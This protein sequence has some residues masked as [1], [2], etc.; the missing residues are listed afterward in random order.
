[1][2]LVKS[3]HS[4]ESVKFS[5]TLECNTDAR[6][7]TSKLFVDKLKLTPRHSDSCKRNQLS[8]KVPNL[9]R[10]P[11]NKIRKKRKRTLKS[12]KLVK[13]RIKK[14]NKSLTSVSS[15]T[16]RLPLQSTNLLKLVKSSRDASWSREKRAKNARCVLKT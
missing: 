14:S 7:K 8:R 12:Q 4:R 6:L 11:L 1:M 10:N 15:L 5:A 13:T 16:S 3:T 9:L 2:T